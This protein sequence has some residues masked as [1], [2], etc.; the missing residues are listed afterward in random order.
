MGQALARRVIG[1]DCAAHVIGET[2][3]LRIAEANAAGTELEGLTLANSKIRGRTGVSIIGVWDHGRLSSVEPEM[4]IKRQTVL[5]LAG[6]A[7]DHRRRRPSRA[8]YQQHFEGRGAF[9]HHHRKGARARGESSRGDHRRCH[10]DGAVE[11]DGVRTV[12]PEP[13]IIL[14]AD[15][16]LLLI[17]T[18]EAE[19][20][21]LKAFEP[22]LAPAALRKKWERERRA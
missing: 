22:E 12:N 6:T 2:N 15:G 18:L 5:V 14:P 16:K 10:P 3:G 7:G 20:K 21:F 9:H 13:Y 11:H 4:V 1:R 8:G 17:G 19:E